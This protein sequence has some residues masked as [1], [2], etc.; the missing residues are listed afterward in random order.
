MR[1]SSRVRV[2]QSIV[3]YSFTRGVTE[4]ENSHAQPNQK[5]ISEAVG[6]P[7]YKTSVR[8]KVVQ[9]VQAN[10]YCSTPPLTLTNYNTVGYSILLF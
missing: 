2:A 4:I 6:R 10:N 9:A 8:E 7:N 3:P 5:K 1:W